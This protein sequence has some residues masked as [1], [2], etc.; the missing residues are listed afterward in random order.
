MVPRS[1]ITMEY[2]K[3][4]HHKQVVNKGA[5][6]TVCGET[7]CYSYLCWGYGTVH[8]HL[9]NFCYYKWQSFEEAAVTEKP[10]Q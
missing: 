10:F 6:I 5:H 1:S 8:C 7:Y 2:S 4:F 9:F 3:I